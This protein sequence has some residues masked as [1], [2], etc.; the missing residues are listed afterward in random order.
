MGGI[1]PVWGIR[2]PFQSEVADAAQF[3]QFAD[4]VDAALDLLDAAGAS[5]AGRPYLHLSR[6]E[7]TPTMAANTNNAITWT[8]QHDDPDN[9]WSAGFNVPLPTPGLY[10]VGVRVEQ[11]SPVTTVT[12]Q[13]ITVLVNSVVRLSGKLDLPAGNTTPQD[14]GV[15]GVVWCQSAGHNL[16]VQYRWNGTGGPSN[17]PTSQLWVARLVDL[18]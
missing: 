6:A 3:Q 9:W 17:S 18:S 2:F 14:Y 7:G 8:T 15:S 13:V 10:Q 5:A 16:Q 12:S 11:H 4:D 1:T